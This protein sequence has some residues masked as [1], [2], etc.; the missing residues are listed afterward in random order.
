MIEPKELRIG[1]IVFDPD[2]KDND[3]DNLGKGVYRISPWAIEKQYS[4]HLKLTGIPLTSEWLRRFGFERD[5][6]FVLLFN[7]G[8]MSISIKENKY[9]GR[10]FFNSWAIIEEMPA[11]VH[12]LQ[13]LYFALTGQ[14]LELK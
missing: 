3:L 4:C 2:R 8:K 6:N 5:V 10:V 11:Y 14:E 9:N 7:K 1:N 13:N 12:Q